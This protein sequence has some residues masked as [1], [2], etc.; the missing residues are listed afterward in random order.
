MKLRHT[1][2]LFTLVLSASA[3]SCLFIA[4]CHT[5]KS[6]KVTPTQVSLIQL[7]IGNGKN[8]FRH[9]SLGMDSK[10]VLAAEKKT[11]DETDTNYIFYTLPIDTLYPDSV[12]ETV[13]TLNYYTVAYNF[14]QQKLNE[15]DEDIY[16]STDS[17]A[18][19]LM[20]RLTDYFSSKYGQGIADG[21]NTVWSMNKI[22]G[23]ASKISLGDESEEYDYGKLSLV[24]YIE[25]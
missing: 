7:L 21:D 17:A 10:T 18:A 15:I 5:P 4:S 20:R 22:N 24:Y 11:P 9:V 12:N 23:R 6:N 14:D 1:K 8:Q 25:D 16:L 2:Y 19:V 13:D 3:V